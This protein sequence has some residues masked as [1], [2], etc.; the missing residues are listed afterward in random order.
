MTKSL[1][2]G[3]GI[4]SAHYTEGIGLPDLHRLESLIVRGEAHGSRGM[5]GPVNVFYLSLMVSLVTR[6]Q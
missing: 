3:S 5:A 4:R 6:S 1:G 2:C